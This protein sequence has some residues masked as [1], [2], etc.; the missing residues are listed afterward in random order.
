M[1]LYTL[2]V[3]TEQQFL[4][5]A[6]RYHIFLTFHPSRET[7]Q[8]WI[9]YSVIITLYGFYGFNYKHI[10]WYAAVSWQLKNKK[11]QMFQNIS[12]MTGLL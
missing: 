1:E 12:I 3:E 4:Y 11:V 2:K 9:V 7:S 5:V 10:F 6:S 8:H